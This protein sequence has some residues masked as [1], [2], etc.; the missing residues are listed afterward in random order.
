MQIG[1]CVLTAELLPDLK[2][3]AGAAVSLLEHFYQRLTKKRYA[4]K[5]SV[6][7]CWLVN[8]YLSACNCHDGTRQQFLH[9]VQCAETATSTAGCLRWGFTTA[10]SCSSIYWPSCR[11]VVWES[12]QNPDMLQAHNGF[13]QTL[14]CQSKSCCKS[15]QAAALLDQVLTEKG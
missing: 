5:T 13:M 4:S 15:D 10:Q 6:W 2:G 3:S 11:Y 8:R 7:K 12:V 1:P 14:T 9:M